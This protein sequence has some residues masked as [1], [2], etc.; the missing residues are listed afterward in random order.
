MQKLKGFM[1]STAV[2]LGLATVA[3]TAMAT[4]P[5]YDYSAITSAVDWSAVTTGAGLTFAAVAGVLVFI[6]GGKIILAV[7]RG[8]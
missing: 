2:G 3:S 6:R 4:G 7:I 1:K 5:T 8:R